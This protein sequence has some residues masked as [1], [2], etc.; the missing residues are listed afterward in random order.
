MVGSCRR[1]VEMGLPSIAF[2]EHLD[3]T[4]WFVPRDAVHMFPRAGARY[5]DTDSCFEAPPLDVDGYF[6]SVERCRDLFPTL[7]IL[8]GVEI[9]EPHWFPEVVASLLSEGRFERVLGSLHSVTVE[10]SPRAIDEWFHTTRVDGEAE[11]SAV[12]D[13]LAEATTMIE[14]SGGFEILAHIDY[15]V[16]QIRKAGRSHDPRRFEAEYREMLRA[17]ASSGRVLE[18][19]TRLP[20]DPLILEWWHEAGGPA[21]SFGSDAHGPT[22]V[23]NGFAEAAA[24]AEAAGFRRQEDPRD[25]WRR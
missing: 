24:M 17:L 13:Y 9:G 6:E 7:H 2:T 23:G 19:N 14:S 22:A 18:I 25:F 12:R 3:L 11:A 15:L 4:P 5:I 16:R 1:A 20:L 8:T 21:V 10:S